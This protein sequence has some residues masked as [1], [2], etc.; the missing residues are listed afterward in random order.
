[1]S[2]IHFL[3]CRNIDDTNIVELDVNLAGTS[4]LVDGLY[5]ELIQTNGHNLAIGLALITGKLA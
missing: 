1:M 5:A 2:F 4:S 3:L